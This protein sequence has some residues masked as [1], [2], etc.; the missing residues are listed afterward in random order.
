MSAYRGRRGE[1]PLAP[2][3]YIMYLRHGRRA[4]CVRRQFIINTRECWV[5]AFATTFPAPVVSL[6][7]TLVYGGLPGVA[8]RNAACPRLLYYVPSVRPECGFR[9]MADYH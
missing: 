3:Y 8:R 7:D 1:A 9:V 4:L 5:K 2:G 6:Q